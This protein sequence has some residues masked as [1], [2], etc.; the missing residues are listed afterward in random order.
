MS[1]SLFWYSIYTKKSPKL[2]G[3]FMNYKYIVY[4]AIGGL[5]SMIQACNE[6]DEV[7]RESRLSWSLESVKNFEQL[8]H[9]DISLEQFADM[10]QVF[11]VSPV[12]MFFP[13]SANS[14]QN[15]D[16]SINFDEQ[17][18][19]ELELQKMQ[20]FSEIECFIT[21]WKRKW[22]GFIKHN[23][24]KNPQLEIMARAQESFLL[25]Q[26]YS[27]IEGK[28]SDKSNTGL[29]ALRKFKERKIGKSES[30]FLC[31]MSQL[32]THTQKFFPMQ[33]AS[34][35]SVG[36]PAKRKTY[37]NPLQPQESNDQDSVIAVSGQGKEKVGCCAAL[38]CMF[39]C[40]DWFCSKKE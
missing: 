8:P 28:L 39:N 2:G 34:L 9:V 1:E 4:M 10:P 12:Q 7:R 33:Q 29:E 13:E 6:L 20:T 14:F 24:K 27:M 26:V 22:E 11:P 5:F 35:P 30:T 38:A 18:F 23:K 21:F 32:D 15:R 25:S 36:Q 31:F 17:D 3:I 19:T 37:A 40:C 16:F